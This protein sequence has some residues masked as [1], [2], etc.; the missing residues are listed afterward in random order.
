MLDSSPSRGMPEPNVQIIPHRLVPARPHR[1]V[2]HDAGRAEPLRR[3]VRFGDRLESYRASSVVQRANAASPPSP[4]DSGREF[5]GIGRH[6]DGSR[7]RRRPRARAAHQLVQRALEDGEGA[8]RSFSHSSS[9]RLTEAAASHASCAALKSKP[10]RRRWSDGTHHSESFSRY[11]SSARGAGGLGARAPVKRVYDY[12]AGKVHIFPNS[13]SH[14]VLRLTSG[15]FACSG[16][17]RLHA[18]DRRTSRCDVRT[19]RKRSYALAKS[20]IQRLGNGCGCCMQP[21][22]RSP[23]LADPGFMGARSG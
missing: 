12:W 9:L 19:T 7:A 23:P 4:A 5:R 13:S 17:P 18:R 20:S 2:Q 10:A 21:V 11:V 6:G 8:P 22:S 1:A 16:Q 15:A 3:R 14:V